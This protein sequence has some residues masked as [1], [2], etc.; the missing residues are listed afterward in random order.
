MGGRADAGAGPDPGAVRPPSGRWTG[1]RIAA[2]LHVTA[3]TANLVRTL[4]A[5]G[6]TVALCSANP[7]STQDDVAAALVLQDGVEVRARR[8]ENIDSYVAHVLALLDTTAGPGHRSRWT[9][10][11]T[12]WSP[13]TPAAA[14][15]WSGLIGGTEETTTGLVRLRRLQERGQAA[16]PGAGG[17]R[18]PH[19]AGA[20]RSPRHR[21]VGAGRDRARVQRAAG[22][23]H[24]GR[25]R[26]RLGRPGRRRAGPG[27]RRRR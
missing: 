17:Q 11:P 3:E 7:L 22:R 5:G 20:E 14:R 9:T 12:C 24:G 8:G 23:P 27:G 25:G 16:L 26:L 19:R 15:S 2:C 4:R 13:R 21:A 6:A 10:A 18:G 1:I